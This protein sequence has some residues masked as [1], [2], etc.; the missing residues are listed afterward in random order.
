MLLGFI[1]IFIII[2][3]LSEAYIFLHKKYVQREVAI[4]NKNAQKAAEFSN[5]EPKIFK[6]EEVYSRVTDIIFAVSFI[7]AEILV[8]F[9]LNQS[10]DFLKYLKDTIF[11]GFIFFLSYLNIRIVITNIK[12]TILNFKG[13]L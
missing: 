7:L 12:R 8:F 1:I 9:I 10:Y 13:E 4:L 5:K 2:S 3:L 6:F 11:Y